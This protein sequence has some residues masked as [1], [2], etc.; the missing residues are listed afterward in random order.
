[1]RKR[2]V[3]VTFP[4]CAA[5]L[6][7]GAWLSRAGDLNPP[8]GPIQPT[9]R[10]ALNQQSITLPY[11]I[12]QS[13]SYV[14]TSNLT[15]VA[16]QSGIVINAD[17]VTVDLN[18]FSLFGAPGTLHGIFAAT[19]G[20]RNISVVNGTVRGWGQRGVDLRNAAASQVSRVRAVGNGTIGIAVGPSSA[21]LECNSDGNQTGFVSSGAAEL[22]D[23]SAG[24]NI[25]D[26]FQVEDGSLVNRSRATGNGARGIAA[27]R[28]RVM[29]CVARSNGGHGVEAA[30]TCV[31][32]GCT[33][34]GNGTTSVG[35]GVRATGNDNRIEGN[36]A[37]DNDEGYSI[38]GVR[39]LV[40]KNSAKN[41]GADYTIGG[42][43]A[44]GPI[45]AA[46]SGGSLAVL[47]D[48]AHPWAN[49]GLSCISQTWCF[50]QDGDTYG[51]PANT[52]SACTPPP[53]YVAN[54]GD[55]N[56]NNPSVSP[57]GNEICDGADNDCD[58][59]ADDGNPGG[60]IPCN[61]GLCG[62][63]APGTTTCTSGV[64][65][66]I[67]NV[68]PSVE[69]CDG[70]DNN[71]NCTVDEGNPGGGGACNTGLLGVCALGT[72]NCV[73]GSLSCT[74]NVASSP[75]VC[76]GQDNNCNGSVDEG[77]CLTNGSVCSANNQ[78]VSGFCVDGRCC[79]SACTATCFA[80]SAAKTGA[81]NGTCAPVT[82]NTDPDNE[83][84]GASNCNGAGACGS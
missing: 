19:P 62:N 18:G 6:I 12:V 16:G 73:S 5:I 51:N 15:G 50:D 14:L 29:E 47:A 26:G 64:I 67:Q 61:T 41:N 63:C 40:V 59:V 32:E 27:N 71:C 33:A 60:G 81:A 20:S 48:G 31:I 1:M 75:E 25:G 53:G 39:N 28:S 68:S 44:Y 17:D 8:A 35:A 56:D 11:T 9:N 34:D 38:G 13:G 49:F 42:G 78:C 77:T 10:V 72:L 37:I 52:V 45:V 84:T 2:F 65:Q 74:Q 57:G 36:H 4:V 7:A 76:D 54:C 22:R 70:Q 23:C 79:N 83:C 69:I 80:C 46:G 30:A 3:T 21:A 43:N 24:S 82:A 66:C 58:T 55:C